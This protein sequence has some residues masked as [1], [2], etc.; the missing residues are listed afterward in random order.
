MYQRDRLKNISK[1]GQ[2]ESKNDH[3]EVKERR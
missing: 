1:N 3:L 2:E